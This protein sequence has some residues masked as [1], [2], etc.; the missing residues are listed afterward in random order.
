[1]VQPTADASA[2]GRSLDAPNLL[3]PTDG[4]AEDLSSR[5]QNASDGPML[6]L[7]VTAGVSSTETDARFAGLHQHSHF[8]C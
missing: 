6:Q 1:M 3:F 4:E 7:N 2:S 8:Q 5:G